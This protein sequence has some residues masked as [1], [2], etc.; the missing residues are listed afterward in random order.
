MTEK[1]RVNEISKEPI[2][3]SLIFTMR[4]LVKIPI[5][6]KG[7]RLP[8]TNV[9]ITGLLGMIGK[10]VLHVEYFSHANFTVM[11]PSLKVLVNILFYR[12]QT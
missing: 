11:I 4:C 8:V 10:Y 5:W 1:L 12:S 3:V 6:S 7:H 2:A 9:A